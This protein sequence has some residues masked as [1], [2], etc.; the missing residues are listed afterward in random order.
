MSSSTSRLLIDYTGS[1]PVQAQKLC[2][3]GF[4]GRRI[5]RR[6]GEFD[7][8]ARAVGRTGPSLIMSSVKFSEAVIFFL[9]ILVH[10]KA[11]I[12]FDLTA[13]HKFVTDI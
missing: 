11:G 12:C 1:S 4:V 5:A 6:D 9:K 2:N 3:N 13:D 8:A 10:N 7:F